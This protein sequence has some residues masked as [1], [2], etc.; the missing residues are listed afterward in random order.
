MSCQ[1][2]RSPLRAGLMAVLTQGVSSDQ[3]VLIK[4]KFKV[5]DN[6]NRNERLMQE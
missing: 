2:L 6:N 1:D 3:S 5:V 4:S